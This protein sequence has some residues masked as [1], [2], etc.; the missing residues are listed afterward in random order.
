MIERRVGGGVVT[1]TSRINYS[2]PSGK[3]AHLMQDAVVR[4]MTEV[5]I[6]GVEM[7]V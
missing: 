6:I 1:S 4:K 2:N 5:T 3:A 7:D